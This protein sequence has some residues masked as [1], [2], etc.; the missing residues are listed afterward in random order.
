MHIRAITAT[1][2]LLAS[3]GAWAETRKAVRSVVTSTNSDAEDTLV[4]PPV[5]PAGP[6]EVSNGA[7]TVVTSA[8][9]PAEETLTPL[10]LPAGMFAGRASLLRTGSGR[11]AEWHLSTAVSAGLGRRLDATVG[12]KPGLVPEVW[13][14]V[15]FL[16]RPWLAPAVT[17][18]KAF[19]SRDVTRSRVLRSSGA[20]LGLAV[21]L[22]LVEGEIPIAIRAFDQVLGYESLD[23]ASMS[24]GFSGSRWRL[25]L[26]VSVSLNLLP[27]LSVGLAGGWRWASEWSSEYST[28][29]TASQNVV[30]LSGVI[31]LSHRLGSFDVRLVREQSF[32]DAFLP[33]DS[34][35][36]GLTLHAGLL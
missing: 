4:E 15:M 17:V 30:D 7:G 19:A 34:L 20:E 18:S 25:T 11:N 35:L 12:F 14:N 36:M 16:A 33:Q 29:H 21:K 24:G 22:L 32:G 8:N 3:S 10:V 28:R 23:T 13:G 5:P 31:T 9:Y 26:P 6:S 27:N 2:I 1:F